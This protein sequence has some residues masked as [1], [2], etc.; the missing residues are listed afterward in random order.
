MFKFKKSYLNLFSIELIIALVTGIVSVLLFAFIADEIVMEK[1]GA[2]DDKIF[3]LI[4]PFV[5]PANTNL[6][7]FI[8]FFGTGFFLLPAYLLIIIYLLKKNKTHYGI[9][10]ASLAIVSM[11]SGWAFKQIF[12]RGRPLLPLVHGA[13]GY[14]FPSGH[15]LGGFTFSGVIIYLVSRSGM[16]A[17]SKWSI[18]IFAFLFGALIGISRVYLHV[19]FASD[20]L[21]SLAITIIWLSISMIC[22]QLVEKKF[23]KS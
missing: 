1:E 22:L 9:M 19:H 2:F 23:A 18:S 15:S 10:V 5:S 3:A 20:V 21:G 13:G 8:T 16:T 14:S 11:L 12:H 6:F 4:A 7:L 17:I